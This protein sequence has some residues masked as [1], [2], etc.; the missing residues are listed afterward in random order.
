MRCVRPCKSF[1]GV[2]TRYENID[3]VIV[4]ENTEDLYSGIEFARGRP[5]THEL[6]DDIETPRRA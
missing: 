2:R 4:R 5:E 6:I 1:P 3:L